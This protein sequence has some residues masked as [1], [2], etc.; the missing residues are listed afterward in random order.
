[1]ILEATLGHQ[2]RRAS[3]AGM[4]EPLRFP[5]R[6]SPG[7]AVLFRGLLIPPSASYV[8]LDDE[9]VHVRLAWAF[10]ARI[11]RRLVASAGSGKRPTIP[12]T[13]GAHGWNGRWLVNGAPDGIVAVE[14]S[15]RVR[16]FVAGV[17]VRLR[18]LAVS[19]EDPD[20]FLAALGAPARAETG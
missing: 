17:P 20:G 14:L 2:G 4:T 1:M 10:S 13:A 7:N 12:L 18:L 19:L 3:M 11:P 8:E 16:A 9:T 5:I 15:E 6:F